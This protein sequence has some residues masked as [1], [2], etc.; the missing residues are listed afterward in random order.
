M[1]RASIFLHFGV[2][3]C[4][5]SSL[6][7]FSCAPA[8]QTSQTEVITVYATFAAQPWLT[9]LYACAADSGV[10]LNVNAESP[11]IYLRVGE[12]E[13]TDSPMYQIDEEEILVVAQRESSAQNLTLA[14]AQE[15]FAQGN[16]SGSAQ[17]W[18]YP[19]GADLQRAFD[20]LV[21]KGRSVSSSARISVSPQNMSD[22][23]KSEP[24]AIGILPRQWVTSDVRE[25]YSAGS[26][27]VLAVTKSEPQG[28]VVDLVS[29]LQNN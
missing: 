16:P 21:M 26:V 18:V 25:V 2:A 24:A 13:V 23:L 8:A 4:M 17:V 3:Q 10:V 19:S 7:L 20:Q 6:L 22:V 12:P 1:K 11:E 28:V 15:L 9:E 27:L 29:C 5:L 14:E